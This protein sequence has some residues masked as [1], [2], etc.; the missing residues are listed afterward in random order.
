[1]VQAKVM[2]AANRQD[3]NYI[4][5]KNEGII[6]KFKNIIVIIVL[7]LSI[8]IFCWVAYSSYKYS[9]RPKSIEEI[10][11]IRRDIA[12]VRVQ[13]AEIGG[14]NASNT[15]RMIYKNL[16]TPAPQSENEVKKEAVNAEP[17]KNIIRNEVGN[18]DQK[19]ENK[20]I[21]KAEPE[22]STEP[23][24]SNSVTAKKTGTSREPAKKPPEQKSAKSKTP[25][26]IFDVIE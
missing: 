16:E 13:P 19:P 11:L 10:K 2:F 20:N 21:K 6:D 1:M 14:E 15:D 22:K 23:Q 4:S 18:S 26:S 12:P 9:S 5:D 25:N 3:K 24:K 7:L 8:G 17:A